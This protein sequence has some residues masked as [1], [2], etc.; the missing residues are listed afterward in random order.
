MI[1]HN[2]N[3]P[4]QDRHQSSLIS[5]LL[6][7]A[8]SSQKNSKKQRN[9]RMCHLANLVPTTQI[10]NGITKTSLPSE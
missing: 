9:N 4:N 10:P 7:N 8:P 1:E 3:F 2:T 6:K 5:H